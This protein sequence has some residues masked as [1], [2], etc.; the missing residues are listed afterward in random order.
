MVTGFLRS[1]SRQAWLALLDTVYSWQRRGETEFMS[2][3]SGRFNIVPCAGSH[4]HSQA[5]AAKLAPH[6]PE[7]PILT[8]GSGE[9]PGKPPGKDLVP[10]HPPGLLESLPVIGRLFNRGGD[11]SLPY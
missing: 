2:A 4:A 11:P 1:G 8:F 7:K 6:R 10:A 5:A 3:V 9:K